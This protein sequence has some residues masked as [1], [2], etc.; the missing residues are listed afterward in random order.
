MKSIAGLSTRDIREPYL[1]TAR[2]TSD[3]GPPPRAYRDELLMKCGDRN[4]PRQVRLQ[5]SGLGRS[6]RQ[7]PRLMLTF[8]SESR[9]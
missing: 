5:I 9:S 4:Q 2:N 6:E 7:R 1:G 3:V 8:G